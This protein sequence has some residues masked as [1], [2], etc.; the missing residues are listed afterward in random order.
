MPQTSN[1]ATF[2]DVSCCFAVQ[3]G[4]IVQSEKE[5]TSF[6]GNRCNLCAIIDAKDDDKYQLDSEDAL[7][8]YSNPI[9]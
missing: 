8:H 3:K 5:V 6:T 7:I 9:R 1:P 4:T 2:L